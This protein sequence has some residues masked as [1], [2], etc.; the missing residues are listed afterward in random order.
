[1]LEPIH[2]TDVRLNSASPAGKDA[3]AKNVNK[4]VQFT[5]ASRYPP[6]PPPARTVLTRNSS[7]HGQRAVSKEAKDTE[8]AGYPGSEDSE[9]SK[10][11]CLD[12]AA[13]RTQKLLRR[14]QARCASLGHDPLQV[15]RL[16]PFGQTCRLSPPLSHH[17]AD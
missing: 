14:H 12:L 11:E 4:R 10:N 13:C 1:M 9:T 5:R 3:K 2:V 17:V 15:F 7:Q 8:S 6:P 16:W